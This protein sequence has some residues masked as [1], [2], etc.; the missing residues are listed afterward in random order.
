MPASG[1]IAG[2]CGVG[3]SCTIVPATPRGVRNSPIAQAPSPDSRSG[4]PLPAAFFRR[5]ADPDTG[6]WIAK[7]AGAARWPLPARWI[8]RT[9]RIGVDDAGTWVAKPLRF[10]VDAGRLPRMERAG[11]DPIGL[12]RPTQPVRRR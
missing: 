10:V 1:A 7:P 9:P 8:D 12:A 4:D 6:L 11:V 5:P 2:R 3:A